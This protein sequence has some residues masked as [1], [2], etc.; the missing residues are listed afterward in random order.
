MKPVPFKA[1]HSVLRNSEFRIPDSAFTIQRLAF[2]TQKTKWIA[3]CMAFISLWGELHAQEINF[4]QYA[5]DGIILTNVSSNNSLNFGQ[6][7]VNEGLVQI[8]LTDPGVIVFSVEAEM[9]K[10]VF[11]TISAP[12]ELRL[13]GNSAIPFNLRAAYSNKGSDNIA[14]AR[15]IYGNTARFPVL[16]RAGTAPGPPPTPKHGDYITPKATAYL[17]IYGDIYV[18]NVPAGLYTETIHI[19]ASYE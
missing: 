4:G 14:Q 10:D 19:I 18:G 13:D 7:M 12:T 1:Y 3:F 8:Q 15:L 5:A 11:V 16:A 6:L 17:Y 2:N 9:D